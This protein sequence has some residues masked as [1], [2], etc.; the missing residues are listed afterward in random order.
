MYLQHFGLE[1]SPFTRQPNPDVFFTQAGRKNIL[2]ALRHDLQQEHAAML[3]TG[4]QGSGKTIFCRL[5]RHRLDGSSC[6]VIFLKNPAGSFEALLRQICEQLGMAATDTAQDITAALQTMLQDQKNQGRRVL[7]LIDEA[8]KM[9]L[10]ALE[11]LFRL[12]NEV[13][14]TYGM[15]VLLAGQPSLHASIEQL[16]GYCED[17]KIASIYELTS[18]SDK[19]AVAY[20]AYRLR[21]AKSRTGKNASVFSDEAVEEVARLGK[22][23]PGLIDGIAET[24][25]EK[26]AASKADA[27]QLSHVTLPDSLQTDSIPAEECK[28]GKGRKGLLLFL[29]LLLLVI[30]FFA[31]PSF[32][33]TQQEADQKPLQAPATLSPENT[34]IS[35]AVPDEEETALSFLVEEDIEQNE[36]LTE[37]SSTPQEEEKPSL[38]SLPVPQRPDFKKKDE[39]EER[40]REDDNVADIFPQTDTPREESEPKLEEEPEV[41]EES[42]SSPAITLIEEEKEEKE[43][44]FQEDLADEPEEPEQSSKHNLEQSSETAG[45]EPEETVSVLS[46]EELKQTVQAS[47]TNE[48][49]TETLTTAKKLPIIQLASIIELTPDMKKIRPPS[50]RNGLRI[51]STETKSNSTSTAPPKQKTLTPVASAQGVAPSSLPTDSLPSALPPSIKEEKVIQLPKITIT[52]TSSLSRAIKADQLFARYLGAGSRWTEE[53]YGDKFTI[54]LLVLSSD[55]VVENIKDMIVRDEYQEHKRKLYILR[56]NTFPPTLFVCYGVYSSLDEA[57]NARNTMPVF[58]RKHHPYPLSIPDVL[59][60]ARD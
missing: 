38:L 2:K 10:A 56:R 41:V 27:V 40:V 57:R 46:P 33:S 18:L 5:I 20:L 47:S 43:E 25:L 13:N 17:V 30:F 24:S 34:E 3:L 22:G 60:K 26:A 51:S 29:V 36:V 53:K 6:K 48:G 12:M 42:V 58:L 4:P 49:D 39:G 14:A 19:E 37:T 45:Q 50:S 52:P 16:S 7:L 28:D 55:D 9:F 31:R 35:I 32:F 11:R 44:P 21:T 23:V 59:A 15:Q 1:S 54:Q 8:E